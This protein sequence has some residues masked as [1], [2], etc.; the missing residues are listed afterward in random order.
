MPR[1]P[2]RRIPSGESRRST[3]RNTAAVGTPM[4]SAHAPFIVH[5]VAELSRTLPPPGTKERAK[6]ITHAPIMISSRSEKPNQPCCGAAAGRGPSS[7]SM[8]DEGSSFE[9][10]SCTSCAISAEG[11]SPVIGDSFRR[12]A[13]GGFGRRTGPDITRRRWRPPERRPDAISPGTADRAA[14][15]DRRTG[16]PSRSPAWAPRTPSRARRDA[17][18]A[19]PR[20]HRRGGAAHPPDPR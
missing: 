10:G 1:D 13:A 20:S 15:S 8:S 19:S 5:T 17:S 3:I 6:A 4:A 18:S 16:P 9:V 12:A 7:T 2:T 14:T 11:T